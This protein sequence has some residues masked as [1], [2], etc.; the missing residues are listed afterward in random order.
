MWMSVFNVLISCRGSERDWHS[1]SES[2]HQ[3]GQTASDWERCC[4]PPQSGRTDRPRGWPFHTRFLWLFSH[5]LSCI[6]QHNN[7][8][9]QQSLGLFVGLISH[10]IVSTSEVF[11]QYFSPQHEQQETAI[12][13]LESLCEHSQDVPQILTAFRSVTHS[14]WPLTLR[15][16]P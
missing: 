12:K 10:I 7:I 8:I 16:S 14:F 15:F 6:F 9:R 13:A 11:Q 4:K 5:H 3:W 1:G 2:G